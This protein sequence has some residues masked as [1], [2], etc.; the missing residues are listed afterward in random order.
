MKRLALL[1]ALLLQALPALA[2]GDEFHLYNWNSYLAPE[3]VKRFEEFCMCK[4]VQTYYS[5]NEE[6]L[7]KLSAGAKGYD[8]EFI[9]RSEFLARERAGPNC[10]KQSYAPLHVVTQE[11]RSTPCRSRTP[12]QP[13]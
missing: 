10:P 3:T 8:I 5:D 6:L 9:D 11:R 1:L 4:V 13:R 12:R 7:A 2:A